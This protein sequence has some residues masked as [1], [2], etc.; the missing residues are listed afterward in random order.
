MR[1]RCT[2]LLLIAIRRGHIVEREVQAE[3]RFQL[4][5]FCL[6]QKYVS[7]SHPQV[8]CNIDLSSSDLSAR[9]SVHDVSDRCGFLPKAAASLL[10]SYHMYPSFSSLS[11]L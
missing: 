7:F 9:P 4:V 10:L 8:R 6:L 11:L 1:T 3:F 2:P 5:H